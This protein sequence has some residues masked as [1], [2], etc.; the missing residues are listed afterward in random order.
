M[1]PQTLHESAH[2]PLRGRHQ[3][4]V[5]AFKVLRKLLQIALVGL[6]ARRPQPFFD[7]QIRNKL[8]HRLCVARNLNLCLH[9]LIIPL[10]SPPKSAG[11]H[12]AITTLATPQNRK[13]PGECAM[14]CILT[15][16][17]GVAHFHRSPR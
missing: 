8:P 16:K 14:L 11:T 10:K 1:A 5:S 17:V 7:T 9:S 6:A 13:N 4:P 3:Y 12:L 2:V 15:A